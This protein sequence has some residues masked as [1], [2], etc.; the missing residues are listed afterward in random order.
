MPANMRPENAWTRLLIPI[1]VLT[2]IAVGVPFLS[3]N[4]GSSNFLP[5]AYCYL[6]NGKLTWTHVI[7]DGLIGASYLAISLTLLYIVRRSQGGVPFHWLV[8][9][10][11][12]FIVACGGTHVME[13]ITVWRPYYWISAAVKVVTAGASVAT[14]IA[15][16][17][18]TPT[19]LQRLKSA[20]SSEE[21]RLQLE[22][23]NAELQYA[24]RELKQVD[25][26]KNALMAQEAARIGNWEW[27]MRTGENTWSEPVEIMHGLAPGS[28]DGRYESWWA[29]VH[30]DD[31]HLVA[32]A[33]ERATSTGQYDVEYRTLR[34]DDSIY[35]TAARGQVVRAADGTPEKL[36][37]ICMDVTARKSTEETLLKAEKL[38]A[39]GRM[40]ATV[41]HEI[42]NPLEAVMNLIF[43]ARTGNQDNKPLLELA[44]RELS[45]VAAITKQTLGFYRESV[46]PRNVDVAAVV[47]EVLTLYSTK[48][49]TKRITVERQFDFRPVLLLAR[50]E[51]HQV[52]SN[53][54]SN[55]IDAS[56]NG[57][58]IHVSVASAENEQT[59]IS[60]AD[61]GPGIP[62][63]VQRRLFEPFFTTKKDVGTGLGLWVSRQLMERIGGSVTYQTTTSGALT[64]T[65]FTLKFRA[66]AG[67][68]TAV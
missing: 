31:R 56:A 48:L 42:N 59:T 38:A 13:V 54:L 53:I 28:Y 25:Q 5:H 11:G 66:A 7:S 39:A 14:A 17:L 57:G 37:G 47:E 46:S 65:C 32:A 33:I 10:F 55:A 24:N 52:I 18:V 34:K 3:K 16:P 20:E 21:H 19:I 30:P 4:L 26:L 29:T 62:D 64:G 2:A 1:G 67:A 51:L 50:G 49:E 23:A 41:A 35:W 22:K 58:T 45:R 63:D 61:S 44:E 43:I 36:L 6:N 68:T 40:A 8:I 9:A 60:I 12:L 15:L 27:N